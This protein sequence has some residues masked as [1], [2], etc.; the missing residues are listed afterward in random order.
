[1]LAQIRTFAKSPVATVLLGL[2]VVSFAV[3]GIADV[4]RNHAVKDAVVEAGPRT[5][6]SAEFKQMFDQYKKQAEQQNGGMPITTEQAVAAGADRGLAD[7]LA[8]S[9]SFAALMAK[10]GIVPSDTLVVGEIRKTPAF[11]DPVSGRF[12]K[13]TYQQKLQEAGLTEAQY[14]RLLRD[15]GLACHARAGGLAA[16]GLRA[17]LAGGPRGGLLLEQLHPCFAVLGVDGRRRACFRVR[18]AAAWRVCGTDW[19]RV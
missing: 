10:L 15:R 2:L 19:T 9:E 18:S 3:F 5:I 8:Q 4:F 7:S 11:F 17:R 16:G 1:M 14:E 13:Q 12:D 6:G